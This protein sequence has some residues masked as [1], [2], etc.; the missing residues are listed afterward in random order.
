[1]RRRPAGVGAD[2]KLQAARLLALD[3]DPA[4]DATVGRVVVFP[5]ARLEG[6]QGLFGVVE[7]VVL[8]H[9]LGP[10]VGDLLWLDVGGVAPSDAAD[11]RLLQG[12]HR[13]AGVVL[14]PHVEQA[15]GAG[16]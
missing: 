1:M 14:R 2:M 8:D 6:L 16:A 11:A 15:R 9:F 5:D 10:A 7:E 3:V 4:S 13:N 12:A